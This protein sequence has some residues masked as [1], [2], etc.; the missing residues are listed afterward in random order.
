LKSLDSNRDPVILFFERS[1]FSSRGHA[2][3]VFLVVVGSS[4]YVQPSL[5]CSIPDCSCPIPPLSYPALLLQDRLDQPNKAIEWLINTVT[6]VIVKLLALDPAAFVL[7][8]A[9]PGEPKVK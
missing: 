6:T 1:S 9:D 8:P 7:D 5:S 2:A 3:T 4:T